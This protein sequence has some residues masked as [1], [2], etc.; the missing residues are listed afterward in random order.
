MTPLATCR[1]LLSD[2]HSRLVTLQSTTTDQDDRE[3]VRDAIHCKG[4]SCSKCSSLA[5]VPRS[6]RLRGS[7]A[8]VSPNS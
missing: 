5:L 6:P 8:A 2:L 1:Q 7:E 3:A 4:H